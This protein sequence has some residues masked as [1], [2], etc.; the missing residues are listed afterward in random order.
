MTGKLS[1]P[2]S[3]E[4]TWPRADNSA[5]MYKNSVTKVR[6]LRYSMVIVP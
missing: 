1:S 4:T 2:V 3:V 6:K 5:T